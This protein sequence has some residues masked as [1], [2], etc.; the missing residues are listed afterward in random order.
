MNRLLAAVVTAGVLA[1]GCSS[2]AG[3]PIASTSSPI[4]VVSAT[5]S[6]SPTPGPGQVAALACEDLVTTDTHLDPD[7]LTFT[8]V[9]Y[10]DDGSGY[11]YI[12]GYVNTIEFECSFKLSSHGK[13]EDDPVPGVTIGGVDQSPS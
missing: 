11:W 7:T 10:E 6:P 9:T 13:V 8:K 2:Q 1:T 12:K 5:P 4:P 3:T